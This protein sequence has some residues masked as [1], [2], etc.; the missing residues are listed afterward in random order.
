MIRALLLCAALAAVPAFPAESAVDIV[1]ESLD[2]LNRNFDRERDYAYQA[3]DVIREVDSGGRV[4]T[5]RSNT[6][7]VLVLYGRPYMREIAKNG[8]PLTPAENAKQEDRLQKEM[9]KRHKEA[10]DPNGKAARDYEKRQAEGRKFLNEIPEAYNLTLAG[11]EVVSGQPAWKIL[12]EPKPDYHPRDSRAKMFSK[13][14]GTLWI[15]KAEHQWVKIEAEVTDTISFGWFLARLSRGT[16]FRFEQ[17][18]V[19][20]EVW[21]PSH[22]EIALDARLALLKR[23]HAGVDI[24]YSNYKKFQADSHVISTEAIP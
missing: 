17:R 15:D 18:R 9:E 16:S 4:K 14:R 13:I 20:D 3:H 19:N 12:A 23:F 6:Y 1:K 21:L 24:T 10:A 11:E 8:K 5:T 2:L 22:A 7:D